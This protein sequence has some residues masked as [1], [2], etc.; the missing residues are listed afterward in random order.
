M[1]EVKIS[2]VVERVHGLQVDIT[3]MGFV[4]KLA[5]VS[6]M[7]LQ[8]EN[9]TQRTSNPSTPS[10]SPTACATLSHMFKNVPCR[11]LCIDTSSPAGFFTRS[12]GAKV[13]PAQ[14]HVLHVC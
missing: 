7:P 14:K 12:F 9:L 13:S 8:R 6:T 1:P 4:H 10:R 2:V 11:K 5:V 3:S